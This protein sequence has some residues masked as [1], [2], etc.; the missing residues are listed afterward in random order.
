[1]RPQGPTFWRIGGLTGWIGRTSNSDLAV[2]DA[3]GL[4]LTADPKGPLSLGSADG[5]VGG[6]VLP[7]GMAFDESKLLYLL[8]GRAIKRFD[9]E[10]RAFHALP[11]VGGEGS[12]P[13]RF[14]QP[15][16]LAIAANRLYVAD[17]GNRRVQ[18]FDL[19]GLALVDLIDAS[20][21]R[22]GWVPADVAAWR[23]QVYILDSARARVYRRSRTGHLCLEFEVP[24]KAGQWSRI[25]IDRN[26][27]LYLLNLS[28]P[29]QPV[30]DTRDPQAAPIADAGDVRD[31][32]A[33]PTIRLDE[34][35]RFCLP[36]PLTRVC[37]RTQPATPPPPEVALGLC[38]P[39]NRAAQACHTTT[40][41]QRTTRTAL[42]WWLL[43]VVEREKLLVN[44]FTAAGRRRRHSWGAGMDWQPSDVAARG[45]FAFVLDEKNQIVYRHQAGYDCLRKIVIGDP[46]QTFWSRIAAG[47]S[48]MIYVW[49]PGQLNVQVFDCHGTS[50]GDRCYAGVASYFDASAPPA[51]PV[52][53]SGLYFDR[54]GAPVGPVDASAPVGIPLY[55]TTGTWQSVP[56]DSLQYRCQWHRVEIALSSFPPSSR[57]DILTFAHQQAADVLTAPD[58][59]WQHAH[60]LLAP[61]QPPPCAPPPQPVD[62]LVQ[63]GQGQY[64]S[65]RVQLQ[66]DGFRTPAVDTMKVYYPRDSYLQYLPATYSTDD[67]SRVFLE[68]YLAIFQTEWDRFEQI[69]DTD[70]R[71]WD[72]DAVPAGPFLDYLGTQWLGL[73][74]ERTWTA[75]QKRR[76]IAAAPKIFPQ[77]GK[78]AGLR[79]LIAVYLANFTGM[80]TATV[81][82]SGF[83]QIL[84]SFRERQYLFV[85]QGAASRL[86]SGAPLWSDGVVRRLQLGVYSQVG[87]AELVSTGDPPLDMFNRSAHKFRV[88]FPAG[89]LRNPADEAMLR[90]AIDADKPAHTSYD[91]RL[92]EARFRVGDQSTIGVDTIVGGVPV[93]RLGSASCQDLPPS[94]QPVGR[95]GYDTILSGAGGSE[96]RL[97]PGVSLG[98]V[99]ALA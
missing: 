44:A 98:G 19:S 70:Q 85:N 10:T 14:T 37:G 46:T 71:Y 89:W 45:Q 7:G 8:V 52:A 76:F 56:L 26:G 95:L 32:F 67:E 11:E 1:M 86:G 30:L 29:A 96:M 60:T 18:V 4:R 16:N 72:P 20:G 69:I 78:P 49:T 24:A 99:S 28:Q 81:L 92:V 97:A 25:L 93:M 88:S 68:H 79:N 84:E 51:P 94:L 66:G 57:I 90:R 36:E 59:A 42:G 80:E 5:S 9:P 22:A 48:G 74:L 53:G 63:S 91:L 83:P 39:F 47:E 27:K 65:I 73:T 12:G 33:S 75:E 62:F 31:L 21:E 38:P 43:Y 23:G 77:R 50:Y 58:D 2:S 17:T 87:E 41:A 40:A 64:L 34:Q 54:S 3:H 35:N 15:A 13:R 6:L 61:V 82:A 55:L